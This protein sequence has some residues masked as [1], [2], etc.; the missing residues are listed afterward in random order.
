ML[1]AIILQTN[2]TLSK[3][4]LQTLL[5]ICCFFKK[6]K[7]HASGAC[8]ADIHFIHSQPTEDR[9][10][11]SSNATTHEYLYCTGLRCK[12]TSCEYNAFISTDLHCLPGHDFIIHIIETRRN[13]KVRNRDT[14]VIQSFN[15]KNRWLECSGQ[16]ICVISN[17][18]R[19]D[20]SVNTS[21]VSD[22]PEHYLKI[23]SVSGK[24]LIKGGDEVKF[25]HPTNN[26]YLYCS[27]RWCDLLPECEDGATSS[28]SV[29]NG[30]EE[31]E[32]HA[33][34]LF[35]IEKLHN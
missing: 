12:S 30:D 33:P 28:D 35:R 13:R 4:E 9:I 31:L 25:K 2:G 22:C 17:C 20:G 14:I 26:T 29:A 21:E 7:M 10:R 32:C 34:T 8:S 24:N 3:K 15:K 1:I 16:N 23:I 19:N 5:Q 11:L 6:K 18:Q 27:P